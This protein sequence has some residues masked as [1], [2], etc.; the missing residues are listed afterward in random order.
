M[1]N[2]CKSR[3]LTM[4]AKP[5]GDHKAHGDCCLS[6]GRADHSWFAGMGCFPLPAETLAR[7]VYAFYHTGNSSAP[8]G[9]G[10]LHPSSTS[11]MARLM[12][13]VCNSVPVVYLDPKR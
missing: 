13:S 4:I 7:Q 8:R 11:N 6:G 9:T 12:N 5:H 1:L 3:G 2:P 10:E